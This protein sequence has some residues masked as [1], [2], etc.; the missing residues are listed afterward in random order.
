MRYIST[1]GGSEPREF[2]EILLEGLAPDGG[3]YV[4]ETYPEFTGEELNSMR[5]KGYHDVAFAVLR[6][7]I[8]DIPEEDLK[9]IIARTYTKE[10]F[11]TP[12]ITPI[13]RLEN[14]VA[15]L[16][17]SNGPTLAFKDVPLQLLGNLMEYVLAENGRE[18]NILGA[19]SGDT[20]S[21]AGDAP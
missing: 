6:R 9:K 10:V 2:K 15:L 1:R 5:G 8:T 4:P 16:Q 21:A 13:K 7:F 19:T 20:G 11:G 14:G 3:L 18:L 12:E 17:L